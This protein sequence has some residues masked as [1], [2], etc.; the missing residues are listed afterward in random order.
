MYDCLIT[1]RSVMPAQ[2]AEGILHAQ[3]IG[4]T[5]RRTP[6]WMENQGCGYSLRLHCIQLP[7]ATQLLEQHNIPY[8]KSY[9]H[10]DGG[11]L[12]EMHL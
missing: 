11:W 6:K 10:A 12:E 8:R 2:R 7:Q 5:V 3:K 4:C 1:F 9:R